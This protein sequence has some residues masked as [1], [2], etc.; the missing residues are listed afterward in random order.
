MGDAYSYASISILY[1]VILLK[2]VMTSPLVVYAVWVLYSNLLI[3]SD[4]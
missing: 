4:V 3:E 2:F 1:M